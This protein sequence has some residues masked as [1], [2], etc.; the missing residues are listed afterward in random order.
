MKIAVTL[1]SSAQDNHPVK[2]SRLGASLNFSKQTGLQAN[3]CG[4]DCR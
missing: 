1:N 4:N 3:G 2:R